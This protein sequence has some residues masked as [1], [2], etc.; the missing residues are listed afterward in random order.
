[1]GLLVVY[2]VNFV[3]LLASVDSRVRG[4]DGVV[5][6]YVCGVACGLAE[7]SKNKAL[8]LALAFNVVFP[9]SAKRAY[10]R[11][12]LKAKRLQAMQWCP[13]FQGL[14]AISWRPLF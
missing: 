12:V 5:G 11:S 8:F 1:M 9:K 14:Q 6:C 10:E 2:C 4:N 7:K 3:L 13:V